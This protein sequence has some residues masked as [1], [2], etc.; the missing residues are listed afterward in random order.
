MNLATF[1][2]TAKEGILAEAVDYARTLPPLKNA[3]ESQLRNH[4]PRV[5]EAICKDLRTSQSRTQS[6]AKSHGQ[7]PPSHESAAHVHGRERALGGLHIEELIAEYRALRSSVLRL[8]GDAHRPDDDSIREVGRFNEAVDQAVAE[9]VKDFVAE[10]EKW[11]Q[12]FLGILGHDLRSPL[13]AMALATRLLEQSAP[14]SLS[15]SISVLARSERR[16]NSLLDS[17]LEYNRSIL[18][19]G[20]TIHRQMTDLGT[21]CAEELEILRAAHPDAKI[22]LEVGGDAQGLFD[23]YRVREALANLVTNAVKHGMPNE[24]VSVRLESDA[25]ALRIAVENAVVRDIPASEFERL[26]EPLH[27]GATPCPGSDRTHLGLGLFIARQIARAHGGN[28]VGDSSA[29]KVRF[30]IHLPRSSK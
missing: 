11:Q 7:A 26:F 21:A 20:M 14:E 22:E 25:S 3:S 30:T 4:L 9:S 19:G 1:I 8:W 5:L 27:R 2:E 28:V 16:M 12:I 29:G 10:T 23:L 18:G 15:P 24:R 6:I 13:N 17:L